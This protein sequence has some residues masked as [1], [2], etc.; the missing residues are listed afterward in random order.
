MKKRII[1]IVIGLMLMI[2]AALTYAGSGLLSGFP[3]SAAE[4]DTVTFTPALS[5]EE[6]GSLEASVSPSSGASLSVSG[7]TIKVSFSSAGTYTVS[8]SA[9]DRSD[10]CTVT[11]AEAE[12]SSGSDEGSGDDSS[13]DDSSGDDGS[14]GDDSGDDSSGD[15]GSGGDDTGDDSSGDETSRDGESGKDPAGE[16]GGYGDEMKGTGKGSGAKAGMGGAM[17]GRSVS[18][19]G[20]DSGAGSLSSGSSG[21]EDK[22]TYAGSADNYLESLR[23]K[24]HRFSQAFHKTSDTYF[25]TLKSGTD[26]VEVSAEPSDSDAQVVITGTESLTT[27]RNKIMVSVTA[28]NGD[29]RVYRIYADVK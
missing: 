25:I 17:R 16:K 1:Y 24:G 21:S 27:G 22:T 9:G 18:V 4:G 6:S 14:G 28:E 26:S 2:P 10:S 11:V 7:D 8:A 20:G 15:D 19:S 29:V 5:D 13:G 12:D 23:V 3:S